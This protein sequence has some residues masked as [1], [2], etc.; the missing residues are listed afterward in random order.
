MSEMSRHRLSNSATSR[1]KSELHLLSHQIFNYYCAGKL[2]LDYYTPRVAS[3]PIH[4]FF[5][6]NINQKTDILL[7]VITFFLSCCL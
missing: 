4:F 7:H 5:L 3:D 2:Y 6:Q 1:N